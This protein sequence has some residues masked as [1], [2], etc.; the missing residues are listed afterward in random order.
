MHRSAFLQTTGEAKYVSDISFQGLHAAFVLSE[1]AK[2][3]FEITSVP[4]NCA[5]FSANDLKEEHNKIGPV[6]KDEQLFRKGTVTS[7]GQPIGMVVADSHEEAV[8]A[9]AS[10]KVVYDEV[11][12]PIL[13][14]AE[15]IAHD[16]F[17][18]VVHRLDDGDVDQAFAADGS[19]KIVE[20]EVS[21]G[22]QEHFYLETNCVLVVPGEEDE[23]TVYASTQNPNKTQNFAAHVCGIQASA[24]VCHTKRMGGGF[25]GKETRSVFISSA[26]ALAAHRLKKP[27]K[28]LIERTST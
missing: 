24:V 8:K 13:S 16:A 14:I 4:S 12:T 21:V 19:V 7:L 6:I 3:K 28:M 10:V 17:H 15:A 26:C 18:P 9:A 22:A 20:G 27:V 23:L 1:R 2:A 25:G 11:E 5:F